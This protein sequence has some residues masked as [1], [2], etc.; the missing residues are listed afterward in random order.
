L[1]SPLHLIYRLAR[2]NPLKAFL[3]VGFASFL[4]DGP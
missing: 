4:L 2:G 3:F 1:S